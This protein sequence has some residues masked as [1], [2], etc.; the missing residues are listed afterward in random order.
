MPNGWTITVHGGFAWVFEGDD[1]NGRAR[2]VTVG[3]YV[4]PKGHPD[5]HPHRMVLRVPEQFLNQSK[6]TLPY[7]TIAGS[8]MFELLDEV[9]LNDAATGEIVRTISSTRPK[10]WNDFFWVYDA[11]RFRDRTGKQR[12]PLG[13]WRNR[14]LTQLILTG[15]ELEVLP[16]KHGGVYEISDGKTTFEQPLA[17]HIV[18]HPRWPAPAEVEF[19]TR[20]GN[21]VARPTDFDIAAECGCS[22]EPPVGPIAGFDLTFDL[23]Q[24]PRNAP[25]FNP[26]FRGHTPPASA[27]AP[28]ADCPPRAY[29]I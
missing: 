20:H 24:D 3:P 19:R 21:V 23:Y 8:H 13:N 2:Q 25:Q 27:N 16:S 28:G 29:S 7:Q 1:T 6:T 22:H 11:D 14:L 17:T 12:T 18:Y 9:T 4:K 26:R 10:G 5:Y 15:G